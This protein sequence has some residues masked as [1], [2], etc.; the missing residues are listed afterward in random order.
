LRS[1]QTKAA[2]V[3]ALKWKEAHAPEWAEKARRV[4]LAAISLEKAVEA[5][6][7]KS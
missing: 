1:E 7:R 5:C 2:A 3:A 4:V 6:R